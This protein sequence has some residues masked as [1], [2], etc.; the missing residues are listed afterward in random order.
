MVKFLTSSKKSKEV[1]LSE[2]EVTLHSETTEG[3]MHLSHFSVGFEG[4]FWGIHKVLRSYVIEIMDFQ[5]FLFLHIFVHF[6]SINA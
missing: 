4:S 6:S 1:S 3:V 2:T 5:N